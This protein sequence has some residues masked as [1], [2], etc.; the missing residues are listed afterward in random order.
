MYI[1]ITYRR[2]APDMPRRSFKCVWMI[3][4]DDCVCRPPCTPMIILISGRF[5]S[6]NKPPTR[7]DP[8]RVFETYLDGFEGI[9]SRVTRRRCAC[10]VKPSTCARFTRVRHMCVTLSF[11]ILFLLVLLHFC[12][13]F[14]AVDM[15]VRFVEHNIL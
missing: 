6:I 12:L 8:L 7:S 4:C 5:K 3:S 15:C 13:S 2:I 14:E 1:S 10:R 11:H 9:F